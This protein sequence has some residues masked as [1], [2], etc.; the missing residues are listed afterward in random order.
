[1]EK[2]ISIKLTLIG[3]ERSGKTC[4]VTRFVENKFNEDYKVTIGA[5]FMSKIITLNGKSYKLQIWDTAGQAKFRSLIP[6]YFKGA[7]GIIIVL[8]LSDPEGLNETKKIIN[9]NKAKYFDQGQK[10][11][12]IGSYNDLDRERKISYDEVFNYARDADCAYMEASA[13]TGFNIDKVFET[14]LKMILGN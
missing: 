2:E 1:M 13:K 9:E 7:E 10:L 14:M 5:A 12:I 6:L 11:L 8:N 3:A 4:L